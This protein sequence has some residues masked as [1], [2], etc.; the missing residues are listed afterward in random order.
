MAKIFPRTKAKMT[1]KVVYSY[2]MCKNYFQLNCLIGV[3]LYDGK[4]PKHLK[5]V[6]LFMNKNLNQYVS[7]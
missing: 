1:E 4:N 7:I 6:V 2:Q 3:I 5:F